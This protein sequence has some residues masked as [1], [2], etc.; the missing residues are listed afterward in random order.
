MP[1][2]QKARLVQAE[3]C[4]RR[5]CPRLGG[6]VSFRYCR[7][8][9][10]RGGICWKILDC[11]WETFDVVRYLRDTLEPEIFEGLTQPKAPRKMSQLIETLEASRRRL[12]S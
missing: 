7:D 9:D 4:L 8:A 1:L 2:N 6:E 12:R 10:P 5:R 3:N 11:W